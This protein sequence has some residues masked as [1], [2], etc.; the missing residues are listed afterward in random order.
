[1]EWPGRVLPGIAPVAE[2]SEWSKSTD[3]ATSMWVTLRAD[4]F[5]PFFSN[6]KDV[7]TLTATAFDLD[8]KTTGAVVAPETVHVGEWRGI[9]YMYRKRDNYYEQWRECLSVLGCVM[10]CVLVERG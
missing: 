2:R 1:M 8:K 3:M 10:R 7:S 6:G 9:I 5:E 4:E